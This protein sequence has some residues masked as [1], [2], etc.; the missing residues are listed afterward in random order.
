MNIPVFASK[1]LIATF[2]EKQISQNDKELAC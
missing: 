2:E 1:N